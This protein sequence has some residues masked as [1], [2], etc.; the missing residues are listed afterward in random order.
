MYWLGK[1]YSQRQQQQ[2]GRQSSSSQ[3]GLMEGESTRTDQTPGNPEEVMLEERK[4]VRR[5][6]VG[7]VIVG[8]AWI[9]WIIVFQILRDYFPQ[10]WMVRSPNE[11]E[12][13]GW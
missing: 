5:S 1:Q 13:T 11:A 7:V 6:L 8:I 10:S 4:W 2:Q 3:E 12:Y 9:T